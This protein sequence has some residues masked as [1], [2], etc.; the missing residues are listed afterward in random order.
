MLLKKKDPYSQNRAILL[1]AVV[2]HVQCQS[3][4]K[5]SG[6]SGVRET[7]I[8]EQEPP[9][10]CRGRT[11]GRGGRGEAELE[12]LAVAPPSGLSFEWRPLLPRRKPGPR[13]NH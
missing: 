7:G 8:Q 13:G 3:P 5:S 10:P 4:G 12:R 9:A 1:C 2:G 11:G 6:F